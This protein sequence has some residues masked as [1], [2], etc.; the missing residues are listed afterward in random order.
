VRFSQAV[1]GTGSEPLL[2]YGCCVKPP[3]AAA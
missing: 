1:R 3:N 2:S